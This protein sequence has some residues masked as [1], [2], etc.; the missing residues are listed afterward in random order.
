MSVL[1]ILNVAVEFAGCIVFLALGVSGCLYAYGFAGESL[2]SRFRWRAE[3]RGA[4]RWL[5][6]LVVVLSLAGLVL[7]VRELLVSQGPPNQSIQRMGASRL[8]HL[9]F[10]YQQRLAPTA[11]ARRWANNHEYECVI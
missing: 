4:L 6:P 2:F 7:Q 3:F 9:Q 5:A 10:V 11:D 1:W 8:D